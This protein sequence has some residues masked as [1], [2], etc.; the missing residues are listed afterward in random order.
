MHLLGEIRAEHGDERF[1]V[2]VVHG[3]CLVPA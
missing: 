2:A 1:R 3:A